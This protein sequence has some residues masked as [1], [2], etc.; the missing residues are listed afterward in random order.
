MASFSVNGVWALSSNISSSSMLHSQFH[1]CSLFI[2]YRSERVNI[3]YSFHDKNSDQMLLQVLQYSITY[4]RSQLHEVT[5]KQHILKLDNLHYVASITQLLPKLSQ[6][7]STI[8]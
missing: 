2:C 1:L 8:A 6:H 5:K 3:Y 7:C 4:F